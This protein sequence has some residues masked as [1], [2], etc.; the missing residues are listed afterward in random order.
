MFGKRYTFMLLIVWMVVPIF[1]SVKI[2]GY[3]EN[4]TTFD[5]NLRWNMN[6][7][8]NNF[9]LRFLGTP[10]KGIEAYLKF[11]AESDKFFNNNRAERYTIYDMLEAHTKFRWEKGL[12]VVAFSRENRFWFS[13]GLMELVSQWT[14]NDGGNAQGIRTDFW[15]LWKIYGT[16]IHSDYSQSGGEDA[17]VIRLNLPLFSNRF[18]IS[19]TLARKDW[20]GSSQNFNTVVS[21]DAYLSIGRTIPFLKKFGNLGYAIEFAKSRIP[22]ETKNS[23]NIAIE[24]ELRS[25]RI[26][27]LEL[28]LSYRDIGENFR[29]YLSNDYD[30]GQKFNERGFNINASYFFP[31]K[32]INLT[33][34]YDEY[35]APLNRTFP[36]S[37]TNPLY[38]YQNWYNELYIEFVHDVRYKVYYKYYRGWDVNYDAYKVYPTLFNEISF[39]DYF[40]KVRLQFRWK[41]FGT[42]YEIQAFGIELNANLSQRWKLYMRAMNVNEISESRQTIFIQLQ[43]HAFSNTDFFLEFGNP[44]DSNDDL[45]NDDDFVNVDATQEIN[46]Q[47]KAYLKV[48]F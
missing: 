30:Q 38:R 21:S 19:S 17:N 39:E 27:N 35:R 32:A 3:Y 7:P 24:T 37:R 14:I 9:E 48:Y 8:H 1:A 2:E 45:T 40:A 29:S 16:A 15:N 4:I 10:Y 36:Q 25:I 20:A 47:I 5:G 13:Q 44:D 18:R 34:N 23:K 28:K 41:D 33:S 31:T 6:E 43:Y 42:P 46:K 12:E 11:H 22:D 26:S